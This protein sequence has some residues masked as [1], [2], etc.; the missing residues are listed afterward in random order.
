MCLLNR[1]NISNCSL[2]SWQLCCWV[3]EHSLKD[4]TALVD[5]C[6]S[7]LGVGDGPLRQALPMLDKRLLNNLDHVV[8]AATHSTQVK[9]DFGQL[10]E[11][12][13]PVQALV[14][15]LLLDQLP[16]LIVLN[17]AERGTLNADHQ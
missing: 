10:L 13:V 8:A 2:Q 1:N 11:C 4:L 6:E 9:Q 7:F 15:H 5:R 3:L 14:Y 12:E 17:V 16:K